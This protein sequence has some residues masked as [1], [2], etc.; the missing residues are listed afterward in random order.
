MRGG[1]VEGPTVSSL[2]GEGIGEIMEGPMASSS[3][4]EGIGDMGRG[5]VGD[6]NR[7]PDPAIPGPTIRETSNTE[8]MA[9]P[10]NNMTLFNSLL[11]SLTIPYLSTSKHASL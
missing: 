6:S 11:R 5:L 3:G 7:P 2:T 10:K 8:T 4:G 1:S 9:R